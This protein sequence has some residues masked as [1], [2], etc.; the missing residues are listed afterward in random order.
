MRRGG[1][2]WN[3][4]PLLSS[5]VVFM[6]MMSLA[7]RRL[8]CLDH[9]AVANAASTQPPFVGQNADDDR[10]R[11]AVP[12]AN[13]N[14]EIKAVMCRTLVI[15]SNNILLSC[16]VA[17]VEKGHQLLFIRGHPHPVAGIIAGTSLLNCVVKDRHR[18]C[19]HTTEWPCSS[20]GCPIIRPTRRQGRWRAMAVSRDDDDDAWRWRATR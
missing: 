12:L 3:S 8:S 11:A 17:K 9:A 16:R 13:S 2:L 20:P 1:S 14:N 6:A 10:A 18:W 5:S 15:I 19:T 7:T 4:A